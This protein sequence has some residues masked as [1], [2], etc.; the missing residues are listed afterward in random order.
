MTDEART[1]AYHLV[2]AADWEAEPDAPFLP[3]AFA[4]DGFTHLTHTAGDLLVV[5]NSFYRAD[6]RPYFAVHLALDRL[7]APWRYDG[8][9]RF[10]HLYGP[11]NRD[12]VL[13]VRTTRRGADGTFLAFGTE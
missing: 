9:E 2:P 7:T 4:Q 8:D 1:R 11:L 10:P 6:L 12:A 3:A 5:A 13:A